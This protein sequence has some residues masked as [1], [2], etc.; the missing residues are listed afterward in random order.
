M[1]TVLG[2]THKFVC[3]PLSVFSNHVR[4]SSRM[5]GLSFGPANTGS[6]SALFR[7]ATL[8]SPLLGLQGSKATALLKPRISLMLYRFSAVAGVT[9]L[10]RKKVYPF[11][12][13]R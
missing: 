7:H 8:P 10:S 4:F 1:G 9:Y 3:Q 2:Q 6:R 5:S 12:M 11:H 13:F